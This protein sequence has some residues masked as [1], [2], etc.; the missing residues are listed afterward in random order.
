MKWTEYTLKTAKTAYR[1]ETKIQKCGQVR[2][3]VVAVLEKSIVFMEETGEMIKYPTKRIKSCGFLSEGV[4]YCEENS[5]QLLYITHPYETVHEYSQ[6][7]VPFEIVAAHKDRFILQYEKYKKTYLRIY[8]WTPPYSDYGFSL[9]VQEPV[10]GAHVEG[11]RYAMWQEDRIVIGSLSRRSK[12]MQIKQELVYVPVSKKVES[13]VPIKM[14]R[15]MYFLVNGQEVVSEYGLVFN[16]AAHLQDTLPRYITDQAIAQIKVVRK[17]VYTIKEISN[18]FRYAETGQRLFGT[19]MPSYNMHKVL[20]VYF[21]TPEASMHKL[22]SHEIATLPRRLVEKMSVYLERVAHIIRC[23]GSIQTPLFRD[24]AKRNK[25]TNRK[26]AYMFWML[27]SQSVPKT[28]IMYELFS[29]NENLIYKSKNLGYS[30]LKND[31]SIENQESFSMADRYV[32]HTLDDPEHI[33][34]VPLRLRNTSVIEE[35]K[36]LLSGHQIGDFM[37]DVYDTE[38]RRKKAFVFSIIASIG[39]GMFLLNRNSHINVFQVPEM[40]VFLKKNNH[41]VSITDLDECDSMWPAFHFSVA[42]ALSIPNRPFIST[43]HI[44]VMTP[45]ALMALAGAIFGFG[46]KTNVCQSNLTIGEKLNLSRSLILSLSKSHDSLLIAATILG[47]SFIVK[48]TGNKDHANIIWFNMHSATSPSHLLMWS[49]LSLGVLYMGHDDLFAKKS[50]IEYMQR[51]GPIAIGNAQTKKEYYDKYH[52]AAAAFSFAY[53]MLGT[54]SREYIRLPDRTCEIIVN[55]L[56]HM[57]SGWEKISCLL[58]ESRTHSMPLNRFYSSLMI[59]LVLGNGAADYKSVLSEALTEN[60]PIEEAYS[61]AGRIFAHGILQIPE[62]GKKPSAKFVDDITN[63]LYK[64]ERNG[65]VHSIILDYTLLA[66]CLVLNSTGD[67][68]ILGTCKRMLES[69]KCV[70]ALDKIIDFSPFSGT[71]REQYGMRYGRIQHIKMCLGLLVPGCGSMRL[72]SSQESVAFI[73]TSFYPEFPLTPEDQ[74]AFQVIRHF[75]LLSLVPIEDKN[76]ITLNEAFSSGIG[77]DLKNASLVDK[78]AAVDIITSFFEKNPLKTFDSNRI[79]VLITSLYS[80][81]L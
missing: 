30:L 49:V 74:D 25:K 69:L 48:G 52:R 21:S 54:H 59:L 50:L 78:K 24:I 55:G 13:V 12:E 43:S 45:R 65:S 9:Q 28:A 2:Q 11:L 62:E 56:V 61:I 6:L 14:K 5:T 71:Y 68:C 72:S 41:V 44:D 23:V 38:N 4:I 67:L 70:E 31:Q 60:L 46:L 64:I 37:F 40:K 39:R 66:C 35:C 19:I 81:L 18:F 57:R 22:I 53:I 33:Q 73:V 32:A 63:L 26:R 36:R 51:K 47:N 3:H 15:G 16:L 10:M 17:G 7:Y 58:E 76:K 80:D 20:K 8:K 27:G 42:T 79:E 34:S 1:F 29:Y 75:Y 77:E